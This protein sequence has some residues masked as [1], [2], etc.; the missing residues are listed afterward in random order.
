MLCSIELILHHAQ[1][2]ALSL[3]SSTSES[4]CSIIAG[5]QKD[6]EWCLRAGGG[7][8][9]VTSLPDSMGCMHVG[10]GSAC[11]VVPILSVMACGQEKI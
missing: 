2:T 6:P 1:S 11:A 9:G 7:C 5:G 4:D 8:A 10:A 3:S